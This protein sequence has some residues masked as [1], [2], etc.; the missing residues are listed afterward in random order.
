MS[1]SSKD[2]LLQVGQVKY[3]KYEGQDKVVME[4]EVGDE[5]DITSIDEK[6]YSNFKSRSLN[7][8]RSQTC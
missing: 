5:F 7:L 3:K 1:R 6:I 4:E 8:R 2:V